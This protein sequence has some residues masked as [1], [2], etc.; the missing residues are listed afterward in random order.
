MLTNIIVSVE[1]P[2]PGVEGDSDNF[3]GFMENLQSI[4]AGDAQPMHYVGKLHI[5]GNQLCN[6][7]S[8][9]P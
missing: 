5:Q 3:Y 6:F 7:Q 4:P 2:G 8:S 1:Q 9:G